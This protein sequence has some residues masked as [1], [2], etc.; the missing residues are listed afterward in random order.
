[1]IKFFRKIRYNLMSENKAGKYFKYAIGEILLVVIGILIALQ[2]NNWNEGR[3]A[4]QQEIKILSELKND[5]ETNLSEIEESYETTNNRQN[6]SSIILNYFDKRKKV[7]DNLKRAFEV[8]RGD[9]LFNIAN[10]SYKYVESQGVNF[11]SNDS[12]RIRITEMFERHFKNIQAR[13]SINWKIVDDELIPLMYD[14]FISSTTIDKDA[15]YA[16]ENMNTPIN[17]ESLREDQKFR[18]AIVRLQDWL[19]MRLN[20]QGEALSTLKPL[21]KDVE[22]EIDRL[23][24]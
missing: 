3:K 6:A 11:F 17:I 2:I 1:M 5:L 20:W 12:L 14:R 13:E 8:I 9:V 7:D 16:N 23:S 22:H 4:V 18:N 24:N 10:T 21:I 15:A 19:L